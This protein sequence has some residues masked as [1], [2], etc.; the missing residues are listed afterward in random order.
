MA[1]KVLEQSGLREA[2]KAFDHDELAKIFHP[3][4][5]RALLNLELTATENVF[6]P[7]P[8]RV[9]LNASVRQFRERCGKSK[10]RR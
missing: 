3:N 2:A 7:T 1:F 8:L 10:R 9:R 4:F 6:K 5:V